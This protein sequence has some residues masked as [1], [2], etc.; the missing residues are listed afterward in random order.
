FM[1]FF[2]LIGAITFAQQP[3]VTP[4]WENSLNSTADWSSG[5][6][7]G[8]EIPE[9]MGNLTERGMTHYDG[10]LYVVCRKANRHEIVVLD[11]ATA[12][13]LESMPIDTSVV[14]GGTFAVNDNAIAPPG[15]ILVANLATNSHVQPFKVYVHEENGEGGLDA[16]VLLESNSLDIIVGVE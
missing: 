13:R 14:K 12:I 16:T 9:W 11:G 3:V 1:F 8:G 10:K 15:K 4:V 2:M 7:I 6:P 5:F